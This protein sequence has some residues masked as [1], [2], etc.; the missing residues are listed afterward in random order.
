MRVSDKQSSNGRSPN[1]R[2]RSDPEAFRRGRKAGQ[3]VRGRLAGPGPHGLYWVV[4]AGHRLLARLDHEPTPGRELLFRIE[5]LEPELLLK[6]ITPPPSSR[7]DPALFLSAL[8]EARSRFEHR[9]ADDGPPS[10]P[11]LDLTGARRRFLAWLT[12]DPA[13]RADFDAVAALCAVAGDFLPRTE[14]RLAY[15]P[16]VFPGLAQ[17]ELLAARLPA[18][19]GGPAWTVR[20]FGR[21]AREGLVAVQAS[22]HPGR[23]A[24]RLMLERRDAAGAVTAAL[25]RVRFGRAVLAP[26]W[27]SVGPLPAAYASGFVARLLA[28]AGRPFTGLRLRV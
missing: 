25:S 20:V 9:L 21:L 26:A 14:G 27:L 12:A 22:W 3:I 13:V 6:D 4:A 7:S 2:D 16:W 24:C 1:S 10:V 19:Q 8:T 28:D 23:V 5:R 18:G 11:P 15:V 17:S